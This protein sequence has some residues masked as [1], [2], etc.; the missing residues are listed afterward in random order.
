MVG[1]CLVFISKPYGRCKSHDLQIQGGRLVEAVTLHML[2]RKRLLADRTA[3]AMS[4]RWVDVP[5]E[6]DYSVDGLT[7]SLTVYFQVA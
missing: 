6:A 2:W 1:C 4:A 5:L 7:R 3:H